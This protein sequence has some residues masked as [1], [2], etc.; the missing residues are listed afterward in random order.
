MRIR[1]TER[2]ISELAK[3]LVK[4]LLSYRGGSRESYILTC[5]GS[6]YTIKH[7]IKT[8]SGEN[9]LQK[10]SKGPKPISDSR[11]KQ[12]LAEQWTRKITFFFMSKSSIS[13]LEGAQRKM[14]RNRS[15]EYG[16]REQRRKKREEER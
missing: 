11:M 4:Y 2:D 16:K 13:D 12:R 10:Y 5:E 8:R 9:R 3:K 15:G 7:F 1:Q 14:E 6:C